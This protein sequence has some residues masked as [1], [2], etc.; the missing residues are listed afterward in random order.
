MLTQDML[1]SWETG[2][3]NQIKS[4][5]SCLQPVDVADYITELHQLQQAIAFRLLNKSHAI[6]VFEYLPKHVQ[7][8]L[9]NSMQ[10]TQVVQ[11]VE[12]MSPD[13]RAELFD[14]LPAKLVKR[15]LEKLSPEQKQVTSTILGYPE[16]TAGRVMTT[17]YVRLK[18]GLTVGEAL[19]K[20][21]LQDEDKETIYYA[22]VTDDKR[23]LVS[24]VSLRQ[25]LFT[26]PD[27][28]IQDIASR[29]VIKV[30]TETP[31]EE[32]ARTMQ[33]YDLIA[34]PVVDQEN[35]L[36]G[37]ITIDDVIDILEA[38]ATE[39]IQKLAGISGD[40]SALSPPYVTIKKRLPWLLVIMGLY[41]GTASAIAPFQPVI[42][43]VPILAVIMPIFSNTGGTVGIQAL[44][45]TIRGLGVGEV[46]VK[47][48][49]KILGKEIVAGMGTA[50]TLGLTMMVLSLIWAKP[51]ERWVAVIAGIVMASNTVVAVTLGTLLPM[52]LKQLKLDPA[53]VSGPLVTTIL[54]TIGFLTFLTMISSARNFWG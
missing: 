51:E 52:G 16:G 36:V 50:L 13:E 10:D 5:L 20:I 11:L 41:I 37:I 33:R 19:S 31:A 44:T 24:V 23:S 40:E 6:D 34:I 27:V 30:A 2:N 54:D 29:R 47:D 28:L 39:D 22:Y 26:F 3:L 25:L 32:V 43:A 38:E 15:L 7:E 14:E 8:E 45:V 42:S 9:L 48:T 17:K 53:L 1:T 35:L 46:T 4:E 49:L 21:R 12:E 18:A